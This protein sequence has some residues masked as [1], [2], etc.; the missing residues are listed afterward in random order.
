MV[1]QG[2]TVATMADRV[3]MAPSKISTIRC[4]YTMPTHDHLVAIAHELS[5]PGIIDVAKQYLEATCNQCSKVF[6]RNPSFQRGDQKFCSTICRSRFWNDKVKEEREATAR[7]R[8]ISARRRES[9]AL[10]K[11]SELEHE[12]ERV[13]TDIYRFCKRCEWDEVCKDDACELRDW[14]PF[15]YRG[16]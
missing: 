14:S 4:G 12:L 7:G 11:V 6:H 5:D 3:G 8:V 10:N 13:A 1:N 2:I 15:P 16:E 9:E